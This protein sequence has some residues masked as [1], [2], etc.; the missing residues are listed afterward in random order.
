L[1]DQFLATRRQVIN[2]GAAFKK[3][4]QLGTFLSESFPASY[5]W[6]ITTKQVF[7]LSVVHTDH[8]INV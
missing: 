3:K 7:L 8:F 5:D 2:R 1:K 6:Q 4:K